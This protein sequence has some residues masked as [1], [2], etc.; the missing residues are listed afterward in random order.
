MKQIYHIA[1]ILILITGFDAVAQKVT[2]AKELLAFPKTDFLSTLEHEFSMNRNAIYCSSFLYAWDQI[3][4]IIK[5]PF[6]IDS[7]LHDLYLVNNS[8]SYVNTL[9]KGEYSAKAEIHGPLISIKS[10]FH[11]SLPFKHDLVVS[12]EHLVF[13]GKKV[14][15]FGVDG[16][17][18]MAIQILYYKNDNDFIIRILMKDDQHEIVLSMSE[19]N[20]RSLADIV[21]DVK[22]KTEVGRT[23][24]QDKDQQWKYSLTY[25]D[26]V[27][28]PMLK[29][30]IHA[31]YA[32]MAGNK[33]VAGK[34]LFEISTA[35]QRTAFYLTEKGAELKTESIVEVVFSERA[36]SEGVKPKIMRFNKPFFL[37]LKRTD[38]DNPYFGLW[39][40]DA[41]LME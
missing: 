10:E 38:C 36:M 41:E 19:N 23:E 4:N 28:I 2:R 26:M 37:M 29:F 30:D 9:T 5:T 40:A 13:N 12:N 17:P 20:Y 31:N 7:A 21:K 22:S 6:K 8:K 15:S 27:S 35:Q 34:Q 16:Y 11:K 25:Y 3:R 1:L 14:L 32:T 39:I 33:F 24:K 18:D